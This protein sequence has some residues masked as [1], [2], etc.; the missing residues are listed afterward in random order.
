MVNRQ[1]VGAHSNSLQSASSSAPPSGPHAR[2]S[3]TYLER[4]HG[5][6]REKVQELLDPHDK[7]KFRYRFQVDRGALKAINYELCGVDPQ[8]QSAVQYVVSAALVAGITGIAGIR[9][10]TVVQSVRLT[11][12]QAAH[13]GVCDER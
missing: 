2:K 12:P 3:G 4:I 13:V 8:V 5:L 7:A 9:P 6:M 11:I 10:D 1:T